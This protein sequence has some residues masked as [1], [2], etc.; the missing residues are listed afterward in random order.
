MQW[1]HLAELVATEP[2]ERTEPTDD[3]LSERA[4]PGRFRALRLTGPTRPRET[5]RA[6]RAPAYTG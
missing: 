1:Y 6:R 2:T 5:A 3:V 4:G